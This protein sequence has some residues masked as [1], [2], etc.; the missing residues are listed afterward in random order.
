LRGELSTPRPGETGKGVPSYE[1]FKFRPAKIKKIVVESP[2]VKSFYLE[3]IG[4]DSSM[5]GQFV[6]VWQP[7]QEEVPMSVSDSGDGFIRISV[8]KKGPT[9]TELHKLKSCGTLFMRG[10]FGNGFSLK[11]KSF[12][13]VGGGYGA[14]PLIY[15]AKAISRAKKSCTFLVGAKNKSE[16]L[17]LKEARETGARVNFAAEDGSAGHRGKVTELVEPTLTEE[18]FDS[19]LTCGPELMLY[20]VVRYGLKRKIPVQASLERYIKCGFG[21]C[22]SCILDPVGLRVCVDGPVFDGALLLQMEFGRQKRDETG[23]KVPI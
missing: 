23:L 6:M 20:E 3:N 19:I 5:P 22:G 18:N 16:L 21:I 14:A 15:A 9:T 11:G 8:A 13:L 12:L 4:I 1:D 17:F 2:T 7:G 10:P